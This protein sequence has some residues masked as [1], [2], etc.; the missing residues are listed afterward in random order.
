MKCHMWNLEPSSLSREKFARWK[1]RKFEVNQ[2]FT[3]F[4]TKVRTKPHG[5]CFCDWKT[6]EAKGIRWQC[7]YDTVKVWGRKLLSLNLYYSFNGVARRELFK[8]YE[9]SG[10]HSGEYEDVFWDIVPCCLVEI[11]RRLGGTYCLHH[12]G[13]E[14]WWMQWAPL[15]RRYISTRLHGAISQKTVVFMYKLSFKNSIHD[16]GSVSCCCMSSLQHRQKK[17]FRSS[18]MLSVSPSMSLRV[19]TGC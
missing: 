3:V 7:L 12:Q 5:K 15:E 14:W 4:W 8:L 6:T 9:I 18:T 17:S 10:S 19:W 11:D 2:I 13:D 16:V 1:T